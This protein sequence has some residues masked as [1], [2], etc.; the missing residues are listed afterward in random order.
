VANLR[1]HVVDRDLRL[2]PPGVPGELCVAGVG[3]GR[4]YLGDPARTAEVFV[5]DPFSAGPGPRLY[6]TGDRARFRA[7]GALDFLGR[8][9]HQV[10]VRGFR[11]ELGEIEAVLAQHPAVREAVVLVRRDPPAPGDARLVAYLVSE[12]VGGLDAAALRSHLRER[13]PDYM[14]PSAFVMLE[15]LP[16]TSNGKVD[17]RSLPAPDRG[18]AESEATHVAPRNPTEEVLA[19]IFAEVIGRE[20]VGVFDSFFDLGGHSLLATQAVSRINDVFEV[21]MP[22]RTLFESPFVA[23]LALVIEDLIIASLGDVEEIEDVEDVA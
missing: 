23:D 17:R 9:D 4:G 16:L 20:T 21:Q 15:R 12:A 5:P 6:R 1:I 10:K 13:L 8:L 2:L 11:I 14:V 7:D 19:G 3:V 22:L 18:G